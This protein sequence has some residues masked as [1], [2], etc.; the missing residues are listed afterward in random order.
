V[1]SKSANLDE[2]TKIVER[3]PSFYFEID[4]PVFE[5]PTVKKKQSPKFAGIYLK[6]DHLYST[7][8]SRDGKHRL[9]SGLERA[10]P[11]F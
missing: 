11:K 8:E 1:D 9:S 7:L 6:T 2:E 3:K 10:T 4:R 5:S